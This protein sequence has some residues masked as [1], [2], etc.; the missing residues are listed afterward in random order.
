VG[1][2]DWAAP[3]FFG[4]P[5]AVPV[6]GAPAPA[7]PAEPAA[8]FV[9]FDLETTGLESRTET[10][11]EIGAVKFDRRGVIA[12]FAALVDPG[13]PMPPEASRAN[14]ITD[15]MLAGQP[16][17]DAVLP[18]FLRF[19]AGAALV[20]HN[21]PFDLSFVNAA[22]AERWSKRR[23]DEGAGQGSLLESVEAAEAD[24]PPPWTP[25]FASLPNRTVDTLVYAKEVWP[26]RPRYGL[27]ALAA[28]L[29]IVA[30]AAHRAED[31]ARVCMELFVKLAERAA[32]RG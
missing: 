2:H 18:D 10:I 7:A 31:D 19:I 32:A 22:L 11:V 23:R 3:A 15:A 24:E 4:P 17:L 30:T 14:G 21:A 9:A 5:A 20:A 26:G 27:Q 13:K 28:E 1:L 16:K 6:D 8:V 12:R 29:G 25:P